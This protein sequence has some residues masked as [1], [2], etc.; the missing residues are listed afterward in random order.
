MQSL[1]EKVIGDFYNLRTMIKIKGVDT[2]SLLSTEHNHNQ[3]F[4]MI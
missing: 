2:K 3:Y 1:V 4:A